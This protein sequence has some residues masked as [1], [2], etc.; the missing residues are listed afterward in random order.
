M[1]VKIIL[2]ISVGR[3]ERSS[4]VYPDT[5]PKLNSHTR[6]IKSRNS[7]GRGFGMYGEEGRSVGT[8]GVK[9]LLGR[10]RYRLK[11]IFKSWTGGMEWADLVQD[12]N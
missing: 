6:L 1:G 8:T 9:R 12:G 11:W 4:S 3:H 10:T 7:D 5:E 2:R